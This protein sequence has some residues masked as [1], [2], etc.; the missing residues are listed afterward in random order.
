MKLKRKAK[1]TDNLKYLRYSPLVETITRNAVRAGTLAVISGVNLSELN[2]FINNHRQLC[3]QSSSALHIAHYKASSDRG[4]LHPANL[5]I[6]PDWLNYKFGKRSLDVG[7]VVADHDW[8]NSSLF[9]TNEDEAWRLLVK[10]F[11]KQLSDLAP[12]IRQPRRQKQ[13]ESLARRGY[14]AK[15]VTVHRMSETD[16]T[17]LLKRYGLTPQAEHEPDESERVTVPDLL[18]KELR[19]QQQLYPRLHDQQQPAIT[20]ANR[21]D[22]PEHLAVDALS[23]AVTHDFIEVRKMTQDYR[24]NKPVEVVARKGDRF[25]TEVHTWRGNDGKWHQ[26]DVPCSPAQFYRLHEHEIP[27]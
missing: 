15:F 2:N 16:F 12:A 9:V 25:T 21:D 27:L 10:K 11:G 8:N 24:P 19:R 17:A 14:K 20:F 6:W 18:L 1:L 4:S 5:G 23:L 7:H 13:Y 22:T 3:W 26:T